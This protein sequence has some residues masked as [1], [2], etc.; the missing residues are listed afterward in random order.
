MQYIIN[1]QIE[2]CLSRPF[3]FICCSLLMMAQDWEHE[4]VLVGWSKQTRV[5]SVFTHVIS[6]CEQE[7]SCTQV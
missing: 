7:L 6:K 3:V 4:C 5:Q 1:K 2:G